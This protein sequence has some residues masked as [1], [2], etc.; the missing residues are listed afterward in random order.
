MK[1][2]HFILA[3]VAT[4]IPA[5]ADYY[6]TV[7]PAS[8]DDYY[9]GLGPA[10]VRCH[11]VGNCR[12]ALI[13]HTAS[14]ETALYSSCQFNVGIEAHAGGSAQDIWAD[15]RAEDWATGFELAS[16]DMMC[17]CDWGCISTGPEIFAC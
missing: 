8:C 10:S 1:I 7:V 15:T 17:T 16:S 6:F 13:S 5:A 4:V 3:V 14:S 2:R 11:V 9:V 12:Y